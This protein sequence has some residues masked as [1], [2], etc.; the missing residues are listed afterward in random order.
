MTTLCFLIDK[1]KYILNNF[2]QGTD[3]YTEFREKIYQ[4]LLQKV[5][6]SDKRSLRNLILNQTI[7]LATTSE[8]IEELLSWIE[9]EH[10][11]LKLNKAGE[12]HDLTQKQQDEI[13]LCLH[14]SQASVSQNKLENLRLGIKNDLEMLKCE[15][16]LQ[17]NKDS[18][19]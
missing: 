2:L 16:C 3:E 4:T 6:D 8:N 9:S 18:F 5:L 13:I 14:K 10:K 7:E 12:S 17:Q 11:S 19:W 15:S 1:A